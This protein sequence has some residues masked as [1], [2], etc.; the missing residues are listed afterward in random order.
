MALNLRRSKSRRRFAALSFL[1]NITL[2]GSH[3]DTN[4]SMFL[5]LDSSRCTTNENNLI[6]PPGNAAIHESQPDVC[7]S[8]YV[9]L[10][11]NKP[12]N[13]TTNKNQE[14]VCSIDSDV[15]NNQI[16]SS[17]INQKFPECEIRA[18]GIVTPFRER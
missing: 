6:C 2:N 12:S 13:Q 1:N 3:N 9:E 11:E 16:I 5:N 4:L 15:Q 8:S 10:L 14:N 7:I 18:S 17:S